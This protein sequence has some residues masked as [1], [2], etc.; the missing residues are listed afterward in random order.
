MSLMRQKKDGCIRVFRGI[1]QNE[2]ITKE[3]KNA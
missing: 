2:D 1:G 3:L